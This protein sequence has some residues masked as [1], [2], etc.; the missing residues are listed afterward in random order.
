MT[1]IQPLQA[2]QNVSSSSLTAMAENTLDQSSES[3]IL[4]RALEQ[5]FKDDVSN[6]LNIAV[7]GFVYQLEGNAVDS[8]EPSSIG[9]YPPVSGLSSTY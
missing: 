2:S 6:K 5:A 7:F 4:L 8:R 1:T 9:T 3:L